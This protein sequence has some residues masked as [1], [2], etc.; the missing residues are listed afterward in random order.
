M[1]I[2]ICGFTNT[3]NCAA[4]ARLGIDAVGLVFYHESPRFIEAGEAAKIIQKLPPFINRVGLFVN[5]KSDFIDEVL[6]V[7]SLD[8]LQFH[9]DET[10]AEC[11]QYGLPFIKAL[12][13]GDD[14]NLAKSAADYHQASGVLLD[15]SH[16]DLYGG[17]GEV[18][19]WSKVAGVDI[20]MPI[21]LSGGLNAQNVATAILQVKPYAVDVSSGVES[22][23]G[24]KDLAKITKFIEAA[25]E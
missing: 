21:I 8:T 7:A 1:K 22:A 16:P 6:K 13:V 20:E 25:Y 3:N 9:G 19:D 2:K 12:K 10:A 5:A 4:A 18:F 14:F 11:A 17:S 23:K 15:T 24:V